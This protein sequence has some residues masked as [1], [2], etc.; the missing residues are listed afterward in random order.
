L[1]VP[2]A[3]AGQFAEDGLEN[4]KAAIDD[5]KAGFENAPVG[6]LAELVGEV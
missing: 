2:Y 4:R 1:T 5:T 3:G 6:D